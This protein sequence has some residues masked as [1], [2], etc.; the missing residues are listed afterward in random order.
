MTRLDYVGSHEYDLAVPPPLFARM[1]RSKET[2]YLKK[3]SL[4]P[5]SLWYSRDGVGA[6]SGCCTEHENVGPLLFE[7]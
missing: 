4:T 6:R 2:E 5:P 7:G 1:P 3:R